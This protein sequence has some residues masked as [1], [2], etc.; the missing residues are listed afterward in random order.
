MP[1]RRF[2]TGTIKHEDPWLAVRFPAKIISDVEL[3][4]RG[5]GDN[6]VPRG[7][8]LQ[9]LKKFHEEVPPDRFFLIRD[10]AKMKVKVFFTETKRFFIVEENGILGV[11]R[12]SRTYVYKDKAI[13]LYNNQ[14]IEWK[15]SLTF[16]ELAALYQN[17]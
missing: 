5:I 9:R 15:E 8:V 3:L 10:S 4:L 12:K 14:T 7:A 1:Q 2:F 17:S 16:A 11:F 13:A 6:P